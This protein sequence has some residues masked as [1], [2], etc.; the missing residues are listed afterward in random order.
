MDKYIFAVL[1]CDKP[2]SFR[3]VKPFHCSSFFHDF[4]LPCYDKPTN[5]LR[6]SRTCLPRKVG[7]PMNSSDR[8]EFCVLLKMDGG[9]AFCQMTRHIGWQGDAVVG[10]L[11]HDCVRFA[12]NAPTYARVFMASSRPR[13]KPAPGRCRASCYGAEKQSIGQPALRLQSGNACLPQR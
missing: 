8:K 7:V 5:Q 2:K 6:E 4:S 9:R 10:L 3:S 1:A 11:S 13:L 12:R